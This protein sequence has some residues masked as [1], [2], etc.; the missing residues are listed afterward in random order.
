MTSL[1]HMM[2]FALAITGGITITA[3]LGVFANVIGHETQIHD[4]R[5]A[6]QDLQFKRALFDARVSGKIPVESDEPQEA[7]EL[8][9]EE[10]TQDNAPNPNAI[11]EPNIELGQP[12]EVQQ[13]A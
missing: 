1:S 2:L 4:L 13:A 5:N 8:P 6:V 11:P 10:L 7:I 12:Q 3:M 9:P